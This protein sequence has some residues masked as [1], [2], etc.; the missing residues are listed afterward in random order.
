[1][2]K[3]VV[4]PKG[5]SGVLTITTPQ[6]GALYQPEDNVHIHANCQSQ[7]ESVLFVTPFG[8]YEDDIAPYEYDFTIDKEFAG[9]FTIAAAALGS[10]GVIDYDS[11]QVSSIPSVPPTSLKV[12]PS[13]SIVLEV[14]DEFSI[15]VYGIYQDGTTRDITTVSTTHYTSSNSAIVEVSSGGLLTVKSQGDAIITVENSGVKKDVT[16]IGEVQP[17]CSTWTDVIT[18][19]NDYVSGSATWTDVINCY[20]EYVS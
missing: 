6:D 12:G 9:E 18:K 13:D 14:G 17:G 16:V 4:R 2:G 7:V 20:N 1:V 5:E 3:G 15:Y 11:V 8:W 19:Y 10:S